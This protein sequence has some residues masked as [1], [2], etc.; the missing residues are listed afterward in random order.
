M[1]RR[2]LRSHHV[3]LGIL[4]NAKRIALEKDRIDLKFRAYKIKLSKIF[5]DLKVDSRMTGSKLLELFVFSDTDPEPICPLLSEGIDILHHGES[6]V[7]SDLQDPE[8]FSITKSG[9]DYFESVIKGEIAT[10]EQI[11]EMEIIAH[12]FLDIY[13]NHT[14]QPQA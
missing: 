9:E 2:S 10:A 3:L 4:V 14:A 8:V 11:E 1:P 12:T 7:I 5:Y 6:L 13:N